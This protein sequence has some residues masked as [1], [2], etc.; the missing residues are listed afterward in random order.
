MGE[1]R[2]GSRHQAG[3]EALVLALAL[4]ATSPALGQGGDPNFAGFTNELIVVP[5]KDHTMAGLV[6]RRPEDKKFTHALALFPGSPGQPKLQMQ[7]GQLAMEQRGNFLIRARRHF[8][9]EGFLTVVVDA[10][11]DQWFGLFRHEF[12]ASPR[13]GEDVKGLVDE[14]N[15]RYGELDWTFIGT[16]EG[17]VSAAYAARMVPPKRVVLTSS[18]TGSNFQGSGL[19][20]SD[21]KALTVPVLWVHHRRDPC[22][23]TPYSTTKSWAEELHQPLVTVTGS[24]GSRGDPCEAF[25][26]HGFVGMEV[27]TIKAIVAWIRTGQAPAE[28]SE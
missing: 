6:T 12:R 1:G 18:L 17:S 4:A 5:L 16:S 19:R 20:F 21:V 2:E 9:E 8:L 24:K 3:V 26:E 10:P 7:N 13:Y 22:R 28:V 14:V 23:G 25:S 15:K 11:S 27:K